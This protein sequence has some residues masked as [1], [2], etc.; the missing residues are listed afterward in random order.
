VIPSWPPPSCFR[1]SFLYPK[2]GSI[3]ILS[4]SVL[5]G[6]IT[7]L[8]AS[9]GNG[10]DRHALGVVWTESDLPWSGASEQ[11]SARKPKA[12]LLPAL[13]PALHQS[14]APSLL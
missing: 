4:Q 14:K 2:L 12:P 5:A 6:R 13:L 11:G 1:S 8:R 3:R 7:D 10:D 9:G